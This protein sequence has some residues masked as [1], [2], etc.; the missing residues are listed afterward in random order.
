[1][2]TVKVWSYEELWRL[3]YQHQGFSPEHPRASSTDDVEG[4]IAILHDQ[5]GDAFDNKASQQ[6]QFA[7]NL[8]KKIHPDLPFT[9]GLDTDIITLM[10]H[11]H[12]LMIHQTLLKDWKGSDYQDTLIHR[13]S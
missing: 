5:L 2:Q 10:I 8:V 6:P 12:N 11:C 4:F 13:F 1:M 3:E 9:T 7:M